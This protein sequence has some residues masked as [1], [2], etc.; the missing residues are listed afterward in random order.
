MT[1]LTKDIKSERKQGIVFALP[2]A[3][4]AHIYSGALVSVNAAGY[5]AP[6]S[7]ASGETFLGVSRKESNNGGGAN[8]ALTAEGYLK[9]I[10]H[11]AA[12]GITQADLAK[13]AW[14][15]DDNN[16]GLGIVAQPVNATGVAIHRTALSVGGA[17]TLAFTAIGTTLSW[18]GGAA[19]NIGAGGA[20]TLVA[21]DGSSI[22]VNVVAGSLPVGNASDSIQLRHVRAGRIIEV[23]SSGTA[24]VE[25]ISAT[26]S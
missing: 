7:D 12:P 18:G 15:V 20:F 6:A 16:I 2:A 21:T 25:I 11:F 14:V 19:V 3:A 13:E 5:V 10:F 4:N 9:G 17:K 1:T 23:P 26:R 22:S 8:G 24:F